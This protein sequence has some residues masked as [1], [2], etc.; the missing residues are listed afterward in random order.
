MEPAQAVE[1][2]EI[3]LSLWMAPHVERKATSF[4]SARH[5]RLVW[6][7]DWNLQFRKH[8]DIQA[9]ELQKEKVVFSTCLT[10]STQILQIYTEL[11]IFFYLESHWCWLMLCYCLFSLISSCSWEESKE[12]S[13]VHWFVFFFQMP[14][15][16]LTHVIAKLVTSKVIS[17]DI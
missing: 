6:P 11:A 3:Y 13:V 1:A 14:V 12:V 9:C 17:S 10:H 15:G 2:W 4:C 8:P 7:F 16:I 5:T